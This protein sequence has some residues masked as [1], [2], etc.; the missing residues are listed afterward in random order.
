[1]LSRQSLFIFTLLLLL[2]SGRLMAEDWIYRL[3]KG[4]TLT[5]V[6]ERFLKPQ[7]TAAQLQVYNGILKDRQMPVGT[8][9]RVPI[10]WLSQTLAGV[11]VRYVFGQASLYRRGQDSPE[12]VVRGTLLKA[13]DRVVTAERSA[14]SLNF[15]DGTHLLIGPRS[16]VVFDALSLFQGQGILDTRIRLQ[17]GRLENRVKPLQQ[18]DA[19]FEILTP[20]AVTLVRGTDFRVSV[21]AGSE[22]TRNEVSEGGVAVSAE[23]ETVQVDA[24][25]GTLIEPGKPPAPPRRLLSPPDLSALP[26]RQTLPADVWR[27]PALPQA[28]S[29]RVQLLDDET[30][31]VYAEQV[32]D[33]QIT[34]PEQPA[35]QYELRVRG[36]DE[37]GLEGLSARHAFEF[38]APSPVPPAAPP[39]QPQPVNRP[40]PQ[41]DPPRF[42]GPWLGV[43]WQ[44]AAGAWAHRLILAR[45]PALRQQVMEQL[46]A[47]SASWLPLPPPGRYYLAVEALFD[48]AAE[49]TRS[50]VYRIEIPGWR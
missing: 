24:G 11:E 15:A 21:E 34:L 39:P 23:G 49:T 12:D 5:L 17:R 20:A 38:A 42:A 46:G 3:H 47:S 2:L 8:E 37:L 22:L 31:V 29:Y 45:D 28:V 4:D 18:P 32:G 36:I 25:E 16:E 35:G 10:D 30:S 9:I 33:P 19:R 13:G 27:W 43:R 40:A 1:M 7:F 41:L 44:P 14:V 48:T 26:K 50:R 6:A